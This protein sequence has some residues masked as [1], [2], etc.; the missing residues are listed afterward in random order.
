MVQKHRGSLEVTKDLT[1]D[2]ELTV[3]DYTLPSADGS[4]DQVIT[5]DGAGTLTFQ[6]QSGGTVDLD[7]NLATF[8]QI[9]V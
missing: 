3:N 9:Y 5:T 2:G 1:V 4:A 7:D 8:A 6:D